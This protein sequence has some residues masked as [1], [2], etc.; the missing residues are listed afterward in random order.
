MAFYV[1][2]TTRDHRRVIVGSYHSREAAEAALTE[3]VKGNLDSIEKAEL[4]N[5]VPPG[6][7][8]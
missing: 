8:V 6:A 2:I 7:Q 4:S 5:D 3:L 1:I